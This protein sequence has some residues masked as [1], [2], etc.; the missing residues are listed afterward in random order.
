MSRVRCHASGGGLP[1]LVFLLSTD[2]NRTFCFLLAVRARSNDVGLK[3]TAS[4]M[5][6]NMKKEKN[7][8]IH[9]Y[10]TVVLRKE[11]CNN[12]TIFYFF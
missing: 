3:E 10:S 4:L 1:G 11:S 6:D 8:Y 2:G 5:A 9:I 7:M 12:L